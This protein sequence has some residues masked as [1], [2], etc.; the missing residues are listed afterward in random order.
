MQQ[1]RIRPAR[2]MGSV[3]PYRATVAE[4]TSGLA[5]VSVSGELDLHDEA[6][7]R[8]SLASTEA[9]TVIVDLSG[10]SFLDWT[11]CGVLVGEAK[12]RHRAGA[13]LV[14]VDK[15]SAATRAIELTGIDRAVRLFLTLR[16]AL[17]S[18]LEEAPR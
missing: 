14:L 4:L 18:L 12:R 16:D 6:E 15:G 3:L 17:D 11:I 2:R 5:L 7:L 10:V 9:G 13:E 1:S 8:Q